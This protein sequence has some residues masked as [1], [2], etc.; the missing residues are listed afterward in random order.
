MWDGNLGEI[1]VT[2]HRVNLESGAQ[3]V[4]QRLY[5]AGP[6]TREFVTYEVE[7]MRKA[8]MMETA[9]TE[10]ASPVVIMPEQDK[11]YRTCINYRKLNAITI[12]DTYP[13]P[14]ID[15][16]INFLRDATVLSTLHANWVNGRCQ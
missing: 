2:T 1:K 3:L 14:Q 9:S 11:S 16:C 7:R 15:T 4:M 8:K 10:W 6:K 5:R 13:L 12:R